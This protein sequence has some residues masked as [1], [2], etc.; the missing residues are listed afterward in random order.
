[1]LAASSR[2]NPTVSNRESFS[3]SRRVPEQELL[4]QVLVEHLEGS[5]TIS[6]SGIQYDSRKVKPGDVFV[7]L[8]GQNVDGHDYLS[9]AAERGA[10]A[11]VV[12]RSVPI[13]TFKAL[14]RTDSSRMA[15]AMMAA[16]FWAHP[17]SCPI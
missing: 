12:E 16:N 14:A 9:K 4:H 6:V 11:A 2:L 15:L 1:M 13:G 8:K 17:A 10:V 5:L 7:A 3:Y